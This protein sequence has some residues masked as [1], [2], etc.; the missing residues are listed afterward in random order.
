MFIDVLCSGKAVQKP[1]NTEGHQ[2]LPVPGG[3]R[4]SPTCERSAGRWEFV[5]AAAMAG[6]GKQ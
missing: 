3:F 2:K 5:W 1:E 6:L 4:V